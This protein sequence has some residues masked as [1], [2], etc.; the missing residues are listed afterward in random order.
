MQESPPQAGRRE[1]KTRAAYVALALTPVAL[2]LAAMLWARHAG[3]AQVS[4]DDYARTVIAQT[5]AHTPRL[6]P[7]GTSWLPFPFWLYGGAMM[8]LGRS[9]EVAR[10]LAFVLGALSPLVVWAGLR[11]MQIAR[12]PAALGAAIATLT[13][14][15]VWLGLAPVPEAWAGACAAAALFFVANGTPRGGAIA[16]GLALVATLSRYEAWP[17]AGLVAAAL[18]ARFVRTRE[19]AHVAGLALAIAGP[20]FWLANNAI[21]HGDALHFL[22]RVAAYRRANAGAI[23]MADRV[24]EYPRALW[25]D[26]PEIVLAAVV[27]GF[28]A[29]RSA[30]VRARWGLPLAGAALV[31]AFLVYGDLRDGAPTHHAARALLPALGVLA[32]FGADGLFALASRRRAVLAAAPALWLA[33]VLHRVRDV[34]GNDPASRRE[35]QIA[36]GR[37]LAGAPAL[38]V[39]P[40][41]YEHFALIAA[42]GAPERVTIVEAPRR[43]VTADCPEVRSR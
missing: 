40:C 37:A 30:T 24:L 1:N 14:W 12:I 6:D 35:T 16:G 17:V 23:P 36:R 5:F 20:L 7:S 29:A 18:A 15:S 11:S 38:E 9:L 8:A 33:F 25:H 42:Y 22:A 3:F 41:A 2:K 19:R 26:A 39:T 27:G 4:D 21:A 13:P 31:F 43:P 32:G 10:G 34:P 28:A